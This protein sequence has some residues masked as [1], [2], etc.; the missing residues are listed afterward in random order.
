MDI[1]KLYQ[2]VWAQ[3]F[4]A[5]WAGLP[6]AVAD[7]TRTTAAELEANAAA[8]NAVRRWDPAKAH[9]VIAAKGQG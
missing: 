3:V 9:A 7:D 8:A 4:A 2:D 5:K 1:E 6:D